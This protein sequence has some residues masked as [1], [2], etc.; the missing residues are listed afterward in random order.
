M[1]NSTVATAF[2]TGLTGSE[3]TRRRAIGST[4][5]RFGPPGCAPTC[6][7]GD[8]IRAA[9]ECWER[10]QLCPPPF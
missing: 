2:V 6:R 4:V 9:P 7:L 1:T 3:R 5:L 10:R 8:G